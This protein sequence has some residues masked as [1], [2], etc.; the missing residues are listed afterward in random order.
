MTVIATDRFYNRIFDSQNPSVLMSANAT[1]FPA[2]Q[3]PAPGFTVNNGSFTVLA[4]I[5]ASTNSATFVVSQVAPVQTYSYSASTTTVF[6]VNQRERPPSFN[7]LVD[8]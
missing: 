2:Y 1:L 7:F 6:T 4:A 5:Q 3:S 8:R